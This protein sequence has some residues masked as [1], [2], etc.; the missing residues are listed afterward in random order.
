M[1]VCMDHCVRVWQNSVA[2]QFYGQSLH[3]THTHVHA[4]RQTRSL[5]HLLFQSGAAS[6]S[7][8]GSTRLTA[9][10]PNDIIQTEAPPRQ[11]SPSLSQAHV[12]AHAHTYAT[13][14]RSHAFLPA[15]SFCIKKK[16]HPLPG[17]KR[18]EPFPLPGSPADFLPVDIISSCSK[19]HSALRGSDG[20]NELDV[21]CV[22]QRGA[23]RLR[24]RSALWMAN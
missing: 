8:L 18:N 1:F 12:R 16:K 22:D 20:I 2:S 3:Q 10:H 5:A 17:P 24:R 7:H 9:A 13:P 19:C 23:A 14:Y 6:S 15:D 21:G 4:R 11:L